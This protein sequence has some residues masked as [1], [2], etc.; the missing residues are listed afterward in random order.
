MYSMDTENPALEAL[1]QL[2][3]DLGKYIR[4]PVAFL[5]PDA[6]KQDLKQALEMALLQTRSGGGA[7]QSAKE[8]WQDFVT[9]NSSTL[10]GHIGFTE[11][12]S[13]VEDALA[14][15]VALSDESRL[16]QAAITRDLGQISVLISS[17]M[18][19]LSDA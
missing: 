18:R 14:W 5:A 4:M 11:L 7:A 19:E 10:E 15:E 3:H 8:I 12:T 9:E 16:D 6:S 1:D 2:K 13:A 17:L